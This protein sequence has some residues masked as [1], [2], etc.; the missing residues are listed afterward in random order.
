MA[1]TSLHLGGTYPRSRGGVGLF[2][3]HD[4]LIAQKCLWVKRAFL[5]QNDNWRLSLEIAAP[6]SNIGILRSCDIDP[7]NNL[8]LFEL[9]AAFEFLTGCFSMLDNNFR[10]NPIFLNGAFQRSGVDNRPIDIDFFGKDFYQNNSSVIRK[11]TF[12]D[13]FS[14]GKLKSINEFSELGIRF[15]VSTWM[16]LRAA[17]VF[18]NK[19][20]KIDNDNVGK[21]ITKFLNHAQKGS[22]PFRL[23]IDKA[24]NIG[25]KTENLT[26]VRT[27]SSITSTDIPSL[28]GLAHILSSWN[29]SFLD[30]NFREFIFKC[31]NNTLRTGDRLSHIINTDDKCFLC[32]HLTSSCIRRET[33]NHFFRECPITSHLLEGFLLKFNL[34]LPVDRFNFNN[35]FWYGT[36]NQTTCKASLLV[37][38]LFRYCMWNFKRR[39]KVPKLTDLVEMFSCI[40]NGIIK[41]RPNMFAL[42]TSPPYLTNILQA[43]G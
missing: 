2:N 4:F 10:K 11:L 39:R 31:R 38:H 29:S 37:F 15:L 6:D 7:N 23:V 3:I 22:R 27:F 32:K 26:F 16:R 14:D 21:S 8:I 41:R 13:C 34:V 12:D 33:L 19:L 36:I 24:K 17:L 18:S 30:N 28:E 1:R 25:E 40:F 9:A 42:I 35:L 5:C 20:I 43:T